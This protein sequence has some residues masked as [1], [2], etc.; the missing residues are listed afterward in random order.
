[1]THCI[2]MDLGGILESL[3]PGTTFRLSFKDR[4][5]LVVEAGARRIDVRILDVEGVKSMI[6]RSDSKRGIRGLV[7][8]ARRL[9]GKGYTLSVFNG[10][11]LVLRLGKDAKPGILTFL[12]PVQ[13]SDLKTLAKLMG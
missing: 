6:P 4:D 2:D 1:M 8:L 11:K 3:E 12:G 10:D 9:E 7:D 5:L 13:I